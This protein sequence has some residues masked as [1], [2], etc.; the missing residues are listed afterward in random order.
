VQAT[1]QRSNLPGEKAA[2]AW[3]GVAQQEMEA[4]AAA[5]AGRASTNVAGRVLLN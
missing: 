3:V 1:D 4:A 5:A 2:G